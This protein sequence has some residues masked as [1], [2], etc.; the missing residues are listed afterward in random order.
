MIGHDERHAE[1]GEEERQEEHDPV[2]PLR[3]KELPHPPQALLELRVWRERADEKVC[4][5]GCVRLRK[6]VEV[7]SSGLTQ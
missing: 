6:A 2:P 4:L 5:E 1:H 7:N 3:E